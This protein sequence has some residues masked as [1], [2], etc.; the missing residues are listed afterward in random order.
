[1]KAAKQL[2]KPLHHREKTWE[3]N[4]KK[5]PPKKSKLERKNQVVMLFY[6]SSRSVLRQPAPFNNRRRVNECRVNTLDVC[7]VNEFQTSWE[8][9]S[10]HILI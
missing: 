1:M 7:S 3:V 8:L 10:R 5:Q 6:K 4:P 2:F 9:S